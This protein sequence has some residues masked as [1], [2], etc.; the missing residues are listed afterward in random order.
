MLDVAAV[1]TDA[2]FQASSGFAMQVQRQRNEIAIHCVITMHEWKHASYLRQI[3]Q[4]GMRPWAQV[5][6]AA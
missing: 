1:D 5:K 2:W 3:M 4:L 6:A